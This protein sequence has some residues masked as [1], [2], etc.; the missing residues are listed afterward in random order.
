MAKLWQIA[1]GERTR[2][3]GDWFLE[4]DV[5]FM[6]PG[7]HGCYA[8]NEAKY[9]QLRNG[10][11]RFVDVKKV[12]PGDVVLLRCGQRAKAIGLVFGDYAWRETFD[13]V[14]GWDLQHTRRVIWQEDLKDELN[15]VQPEEGFFRSK[16]AATFSAVNDPKVIEQIEPLGGRCQP[17]ELKRLPE[18]PREVSRPLELPELGRE[19]YSRGIPNDAVD[20]ALSAIERQ[21]QLWQWYDEHGQASGRPTEHEVVAHLVLPL[22]LALGWSEQLLAIEWNRIDLAGFFRTPTRKEDCVLAC[23]A[24]GMGHGLQDERTFDQ[25]KKHTHG[26]ARCGRLLLTNGARFY[27]YERQGDKWCDQP[28]G[29]LNI[30]RIR[31]AHLVP[32]NTNA[33]DT[34]EA[35]TPAGVLRPLKT[36]S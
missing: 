20:R 21:R 25:A 28:A 14:H 27:L 15:R 16:Q 4:H 32:T 22:L 12:Q 19:L 13:D 36:A 6:G 29:Y 10:L 9:G 8:E 3:Y 30:N 5:M 33:V 24:K 2:Y 26:L 35:L 31:T 23:E 18:V 7:R 11:R 1:A 34:I 17:R